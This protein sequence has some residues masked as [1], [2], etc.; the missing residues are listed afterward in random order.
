MKY[1]VT[2]HNI[3]PTVRER[4]RQRAS[5]DKFFVWKI[6][7][8]QPLSHSIHR[9]L[10]EI[11]PAPDR[12]SP[13]KLFAVSA[14]TESDFKNAFIAKIDFIQTIQDVSFLPIAKSVIALKKFL[15]IVIQATNLMIT[16]WVCVPELSNLFF[17]HGCI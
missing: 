7:Q 14:L 16:A 10:S 4:Q 8:F 15:I 1:S 2:E 5:S 17:C 13:D 6:S 9:L 3:K 11:D 12:T